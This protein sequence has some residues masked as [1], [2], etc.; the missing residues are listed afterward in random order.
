MLLELEEQ[1]QEL[2]QKIS[3]INESVQTML[4]QETSIKN[5]FVSND[6][7][8]NLPI[9]QNKLVFVVKAPSETFLENKDNHQE[10]AIEMNT[11]NEKIDVFYI[12][13]EK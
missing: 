1:E 11:N 8:L 10:F 4:Q 3:E 6:D 12:S 2:D 7:I 9:L 5:A 13:D